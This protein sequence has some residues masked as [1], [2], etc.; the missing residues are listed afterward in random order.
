L[1]LCRAVLGRSLFEGMSVE[2]IAAAWDM[3]IELPSQISGRVGGLIR[4]L[5][6]E[7]ESQRWGYI[8]VKRWCEG[9]YMR[10]TNRCIYTG[11]KKIQE[12]KP[13]I[14]GK[15][16]DQTVKVS[17]LHQLELAIKEHWDQA[18]KIVKR[19]ELVEFV[20]QYDIN[21]E[22][23]VRGLSYC[24]DPDVAVFKLLCY[25][26]DGC[27]EICFKGKIYRSMVDYAE[28]LSL[29]RDDV[30]NKFL[31]SGMLVF[32]L[33]HC[34]YEPSRIDQLERLIKKNDQVD[35]SSIATICAA[36]QGKKSIK[37]LGEMVDSLDG[38]V[39]VLSKHTTRDI[40]QLLETDEFVAWMNRLG[41]SK[42]MNI[43]KEGL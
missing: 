15:F 11:T 34:Q 41:Y 27:E 24:Q 36:M 43:L 19:R 4:G 30:A 13:L 33:R 17:S 25:I 20:R 2:E 22:E 7:D 12:K 31:F 38:L 37:V 28:S 16:G 3:G 9:E 39:L 21:M 32:Y 29:G 23:K 6:T 8:E 42:E 40:D 35:M 14:F 26:M 10:P 5:L 1:V 18:T